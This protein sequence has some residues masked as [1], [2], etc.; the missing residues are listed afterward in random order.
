[1]NNE[2][3]EFIGSELELSKLPPSKKYDKV[4]EKIEELKNVTRELES[5]LSAEKDTL[6]Q[7]IREIGGKIKME[8]PEMTDTDTDDDKSNQC[9]DLYVPFKIS[10][11]DINCTLSLLFDNLKYK[12]GI[13]SFKEKRRPEVT[14][15]LS[16]FDKEIIKEADKDD[17]LGWYGYEILS[18]KNDALEHFTNL[19]NAVKAEKEKWDNQAK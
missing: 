3:K 8:F 1:M 16:S 13:Y 10:G 11:F 19:I 17:D 2:L 7:P 18:N 4:Q 15:F 14:Q 9:Y 12:S 6:T 5:Y